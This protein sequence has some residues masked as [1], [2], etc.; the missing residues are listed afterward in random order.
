VDFFNTHLAF[1]GK[2]EREPQFS[3]LGEIFADRKRYILTGDF[4][5]GDFSEFAPIGAAHMVNREDSRRVTFPGSR[6]AID[7]IVLSEGFEELAAKVTEGNQSDH[8]ML[9]AEL[10]L[11]Y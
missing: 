6:S 5:T 8:W 11:K 10:R 2:K 4:N 3:Q 7:N 9:S 1:E